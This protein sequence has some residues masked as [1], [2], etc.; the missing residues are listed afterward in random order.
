MV[1]TI[2]WVITISTV[3]LWG[4]VTAFIRLVNRSDV[5]LSP[6]IDSGDPAADARR[7]ERARHIQQR[8]GEILLRAW[9]VIAIVAVAGIAVALATG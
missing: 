1:S 5:I 8:E 6:Q 7:R 3:I 9:P 4:T 2:A